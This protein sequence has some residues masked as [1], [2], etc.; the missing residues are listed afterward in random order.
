MHAEALAI[1]AVLAIAIILIT[2][3]ARKKGCQTR[4]SPATERQRAA[5]DTLVARLKHL[6]AASRTLEAALDGARRAAVAPIARAAEQLL[7][8]LPARPAY[9]DYLALYHGLAAPAA[10]AA[11]ADGYEAAARQPGAGAAAAPM[12]AMG[13][14][15]RQVAAGLHVLGAELCAE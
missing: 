15:L 8:G 10:Y 2:L 5:G 4:S 12:A 9:A 3:F 6:V 14:Q 7:A 1:G 11:A 13:R